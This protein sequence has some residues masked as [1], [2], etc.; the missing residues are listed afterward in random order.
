MLR[1]PARAYVWRRGFRR[2]HGLGRCGGRAQ[3]RYEILAHLARVA[4]PLCDAEPVEE[5]ENLDRE[6][7]ADAGRV[8]VLRRGEQAVRLQLCGGL[9]DRGERRERRAG[10]EALAGHAHHF[11]RLRLAVEEILD[12][13]LLQFHL[14]GEIAQRWGVE[15]RGFER[16]TQRL[17]QAIVGRIRRRVVSR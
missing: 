8:A 1:G 4:D 5:L 13:R 9:R 3:Y 17:P 16:R 7:A 11:A 15:A 2:L 12:D 6:A 10:V 14:D